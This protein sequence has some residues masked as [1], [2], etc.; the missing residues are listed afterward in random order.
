LGLKKK[1]NKSAARPFWG[2]GGG[3]RME[4]ARQTFRHSVIWGELSDSYPGCLNS[5]GRGPGIQ[6]IGGRVNSRNYLDDLENKLISYSCG[7][8]NHDLS[9]V[10]PAV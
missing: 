8:S 3:G 7:E 9:N 10:Q 1:K 2:G 6:W 5:L 4:T